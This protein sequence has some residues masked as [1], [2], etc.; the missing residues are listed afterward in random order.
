MGEYCIRYH[1][2]ENSAYNISCICSSVL[3]ISWHFLTDI[4]L[5]K[6]EVLPFCSL[7]VV[8]FLSYSNQIL[9]LRESKMPTAEEI[10]LACASGCIRRFFSKFF[11][12]TFPCAFGSGENS[13]R[14]N[15]VHWWR[16]L[17]AHAICVILAHRSLKEIWLCAYFFF[18]TQLAWCSWL[19]VL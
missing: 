10:L 17:F 1:W 16:R 2:E 8:I 5:W 7:C 18:W 9:M 15:R 19:W 14:I 4:Q 11:L 3:V 13:L 6:G 12:E